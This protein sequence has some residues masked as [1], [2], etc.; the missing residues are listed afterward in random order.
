[1]LITT[2]GL[3]GALIGKEVGYPPL[4]FLLGFISHFILDSIPHCDGPDDIADRD[5]NLPN[6]NAQYLLVSLDLLLA[7]AITIYLFSMGMVLPEMI[8]GVVGALFPDLIDN[9]PIWKRKIRK[10]NV[11]REFHFFHAK[12]QQF[13]IPLFWGLAVQYLLAAFFFC[14]IFLL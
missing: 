5:E 9:V 4:A 7:V 1:M 6:T 12:I 11:F 2:H 3:F 13:K 10:L 14:L 8:W